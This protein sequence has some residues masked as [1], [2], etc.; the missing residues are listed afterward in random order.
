MVFCSQIAQQHHVPLYGTASEDRAFL[1]VEYTGEWQAKAIQQNGL[2]DVLNEWIQSQTETIEGLRP[3]FIKQGQKS[4]GRVYIAI[5][6]FHNPRLYKLSF[7]NLPRDIGPIV[8]GETDL[9]TSDETLL[10]VCTNGKRDN[11]CAKFGLPVY[12][13]FAKEDGMSTWQCTHIG[14][15]RYAATAITL[16]TGVVYG[17]MSPDSTPAI[18]DSIRNDTIMLDNFRGRAQQSGV[19]N[20][21]EYFVRRAT[22]KV[23]LADTPIVSAEQVGEDWEIGFDLGEGRNVVR[24]Q[25]QVT[26]LILASCD[27]PLKP[28]KQF[29]FKGYLVQKIN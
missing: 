6:D 20:A 24:L 9:P 7:D 16:P 4:S 11:C 10:L 13:E 29:V 3:L 8:R 5:P 14:G 25:E 18:A 21:A 28:S 22:G 27:K 26:E 2:P 23:G 1:L 19:A 12:H 17:Y 15:H